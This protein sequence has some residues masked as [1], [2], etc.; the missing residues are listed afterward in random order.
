MSHWRGDRPGV[1]VWDGEGAGRHGGQGPLLRQGSRAQG[2]CSRA[3]HDMPMEGTR[4]GGMVTGVL[5]TQASLLYTHASLICKAH[6]VI[7]EVG[8]PKWGNPKSSW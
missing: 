7:E 4:I 8:P 5:H 2:N 1:E 6:D 3:G